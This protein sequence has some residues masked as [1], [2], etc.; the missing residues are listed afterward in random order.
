MRYFAVFLPT[1]DVEKSKQYRSEHLAFLEKDENKDAIF[2]KGRFADGAGG[3][4]IYQGKSFEEIEAIV[5]Q[6]P[7]IIHGARDYEI[8]EWEMKTDKF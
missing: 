6:D 3:L 8:H 1:K 7:Y 2:M 4:V 5:K